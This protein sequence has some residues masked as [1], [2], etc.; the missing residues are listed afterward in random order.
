MISQAQAALD[1]LAESSGLCLAVTRRNAQEVGAVYCAAWAQGQQS[2]KV[3]V[4]SNWLG[5]VVSAR[6]SARGCHT[7]LAPGTE[8]AASPPFSA[9]AVAGGARPAGCHALTL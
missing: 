2:C 3:D 6:C 8:A 1:K 9:G 7:A 5:S 4:E